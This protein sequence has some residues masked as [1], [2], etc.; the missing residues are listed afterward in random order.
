MTE[1][2]TDKKDQ[3]AA[4]P[5]RPHATLDLKAAETPSATK[6]AASE[7][8]ETTSPGAGPSAERKTAETPGKARSPEPIARTPSAFTRIVTHLAAGVAGGAVV[9]FGGEQLARSLQLQT[10][11]TRLEEAT[12]VLDRRI[13]ALEEDS[14]TD[15]SAALKSVEDRLASLAQLETQLTGLR[16]EQDKIREKAESLSNTVVTSAGLENVD[17]RIGALEDQLKTIATASSDPAAGNRISDIAAVTS[18]IAEAETR[19]SNETTKLRDS[20]ASQ[21]DDRLSVRDDSTKADLARQIQAVEKLKADQERLDKS[22]QTAQEEAGRVASSLSE[23][24]AIVEKQSATY[25]KAG[26]IAAAVAP[27]TGLVSK[28][29]GSLD[30]LLQ[31]DNARQSHVERIVTALELGNLKRAIESGRNFS[32]ELKAVNAASGS[33]LDLAALEP[34]KETGVPSLGE[35]R[36]SG[37]PLLLSALDNASIDPEASLWDRLQAS[38]TSIV[39]IRKIEVEDADQ[40]AEA[41][42]ARIEKALKENRLADVLSEVEKLPPAAVAKIA[43][44]REKVAARHSVDEAI[45]TVENELKAALAAPAATPPANSQQ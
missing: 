16:A 44:W 32:V 33:K 11:A 21:I 17:S 45:A 28:I 3:P 13:A 34:F 19:F 29:E 30:G 5:K 39:R 6:A 7:P 12:T 8:K 43:P 37:R 14:K 4:E 22:V 15:S 18:R 35:L 25:A 31:K 1:K 10:P 20:I 26:D 24:K 27:V 42:V 23:L 36:E 9:L 38:A 41:T 2:P 40:S